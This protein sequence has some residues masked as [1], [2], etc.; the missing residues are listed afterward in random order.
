MLPKDEWSEEWVHWV[1]TWIIITNIH[2]FHVKSILRT[3]NTTRFLF[4]MTICHR[5]DW[6]EPVWGEDA[7]CWRTA[8]VVMI[9]WLV[10][11]CAR[12]SVNPRW[13]PVSCEPNE[14]KFIIYRTPFTRPLVD[15]DFETT[16]IFMNTD[17]LISSIRRIQPLAS[18]LTDV[19]S[20][21]KQ[22]LVTR[23]LFLFFLIYHI[24]HIKAI[25]IELR[26]RANL[27]IFS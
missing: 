2:G 17:K 19:Q 15:Q 14:L 8:D 20:S 11:W 9:T 22:W 3:Q 1:R 21:F 18:R 10:L 12:T 24:P 4:G 25:G 7:H 27:V 13:T 26:K 5:D 23:K 6:T 16:W